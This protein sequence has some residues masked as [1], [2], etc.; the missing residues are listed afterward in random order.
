MVGSLVSLIANYDWALRRITIITC[1]ICGMRLNK[2]MTSRS[3]SH[4]FHKTN[5][6]RTTMSTLIAPIKYP[7]FVF[8][9]ALGSKSE[10]YRIRVWLVL[11]TRSMS[12]ESTKDIFCPDEEA[13]YYWVQHIRLN[14]KS[15]CAGHVARHHV[16]PVH[17]CVLENDVWGHHLAKTSFYTNSQ[18]S[19]MLWW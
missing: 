15:T 17:Y 7:P 16:A 1:W 5:H 3:S 2:I 8:P 10:T 4:S 14:E 6:E 13:I 11:T 12:L 18:Q 19:A 9:A